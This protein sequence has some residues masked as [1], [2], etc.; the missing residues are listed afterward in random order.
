[1]LFKAHRV[2]SVTETYKLLGPILETLTRDP[3]SLRVR[4][5]RA[6]EATVE[7]I[8]DE[9]K[10]GETEFKFFN[11]HREPVE[12]IPQDLFYT[13]GDALE[14]KILFAEEEV[15][16]SLGLLSG[17]ATNKLNKL[18]TKGPDM[19]RFIHDLDTDDE[20]PD[21]DEDFE[22]ACEESSEDEDDWE[23]EDEEEGDDDDLDLDLDNQNADGEEKPVSEE[24]KA[25]VAYLGR[26]TKY[27]P[28]ANMEEQFAQFVRRE[29]SKGM[30]S[31]CVFMLATLRED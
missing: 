12:K 18:E 13:E 4:E 14:D 16:P 23:A 5:I 17:G 1:M 21:D 3:D 11:E 15:G 30:V 6:N 31:Q 24:V 25:F 8:Y 26:H 29:A 22:H 7:S 27:D 19:K 10:S 2:H 9:I 28:N 20:L